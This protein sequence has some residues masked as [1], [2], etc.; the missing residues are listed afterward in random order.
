MLFLGIVLN[1]GWNFCLPTVTP[2]IEESAKKSYAYYT[3][4]SR[5]KMQE[6]QITDMPEKWLRRQRRLVLKLNYNLLNISL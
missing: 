6:L 4:P 2:D 1:V 5:K 3:T